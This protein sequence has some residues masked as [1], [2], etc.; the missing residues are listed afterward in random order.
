MQVAVRL[1]HMKETRNKWKEMEKNLH[2][3]KQ[4]DWFEEYWLPCGYCAI[5]NNDCAVCTLANTFKSCVP[6]CLSKSMDQS[7]TRKTLDFADEGSFQE[8]LKCCKIIIEKVEKDI[9]EIKNKK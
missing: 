1:K 4:I 3:K 6:L 2:E 7:W 5:S 9:A 8:A